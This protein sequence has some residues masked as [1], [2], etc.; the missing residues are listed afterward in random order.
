MIVSAIEM[1][2]DTVQTVMKPYEQVYAISEDKEISRKVLTK[3]V[4][5]GFSRVPVYKGND[6]NNVCGILLIKKLIDYDFNEQPGTI[7]SLNIELRKPLIVPP[8]MPISELLKEFQEGSSHMA[9]IT[10]Q[11]QQ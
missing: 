9:L 5:K 7:S 11:V 4:N 8:E 1:H 3:I 2:K 6:K 10:R